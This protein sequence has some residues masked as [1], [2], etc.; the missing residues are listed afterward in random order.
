[1]NTM[2]WSLSVNWGILVVTFP[3]QFT[4]SFLP[5]VPLQRVNRGCSGFTQEDHFCPDLKDL[6]DAFC[7]AEESTQTL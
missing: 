6:R 4:I 5:E 3:H 1:M 7:D 2:N